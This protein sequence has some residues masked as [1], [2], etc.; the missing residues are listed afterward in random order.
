MAKIAYGDAQTVMGEWLTN[1]CA[2]IYFHENPVDWATAESLATM[3]E[4][5]GF[6]WINRSVIFMSHFFKNRNQ[7][8]TIYDYTHAII[9]FMKNTATNFY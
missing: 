2:A 5:R 7:F 9:D 8:K 1:L 6:I 3:D 4:R